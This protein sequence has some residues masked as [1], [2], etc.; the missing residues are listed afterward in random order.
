[1][2]LVSSSARAAGLADSSPSV[3]PLAGTQIK[4]FHECP[5]YIQLTFLAPSLHFGLQTIVVVSSVHQDVQYACVET[6]C[7]M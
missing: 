3:A 1:M 4:L 7:A 5:Y 2:Y 6:Q